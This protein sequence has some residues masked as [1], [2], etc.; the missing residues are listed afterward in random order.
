M[1]STCSMMVQTNPKVG[2]IDRHPPPHQCTRPVYADGY[3]A[4]HS[5]QYQQ[6]KKAKENARNARYEAK[7]TSAEDEIARAMLILINSGY[8]VEKAKP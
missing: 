8:A 7:K 3:C 1:T 4:Q 5:Y 2:D 6:E